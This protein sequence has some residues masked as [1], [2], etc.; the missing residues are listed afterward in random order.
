MGPASSKGMPR[1]LLF[2][3]SRHTSRPGP[4]HR[5]KTSGFAQLRG[6]AWRG[7]QSTLQR[8]RT[9]ARGQFSGQRRDSA[10]SREGSYGPRE[11]RRGL[12]RLQDQKAVPVV[13][14]IREGQKLRKRPQGLGSLLQ[15]WRGPRDTAAEMTEEETGT[16][17][18]AQ[19]ALGGG[20][21]GRRAVA[22]KRLGPPGR[23]GGGWQKIRAFLPEEGVE[24][25]CGWDSTSP[26]PGEAAPWSHGPD[27]NAL[28]FQGGYG[29]SEPLAI[30]PK[31]T[32]SWR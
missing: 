9:F 17:R 28:L 14:L 10:L 6:S 32:D 27:I 24:G 31:V 1:G 8:L 29:R 23:R 20:G 15:G 5:S 22:A 13:P 12:H 19:R 7:L 18:P 2:L 4:R 16:Q 26:A 30:L 25:A 11:D 21:R 3:V